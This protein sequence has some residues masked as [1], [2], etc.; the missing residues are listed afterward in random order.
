MGMPI[1]VI[2][3]ISIL[4][5]GLVLLRPMA[6]LVLLIYCIALLRFPTVFPSFVGIFTQLS[7]VKLL[8]GLTFCSVLIHNLVDKKK[9]GLLKA[10]Q[11]KF[12]ILFLLWVAISG[13]SQPC[14]FTRESFTRYASFAMLF[15]ITISMVDSPKRFRLVLWSCIISMLGAAGLA[16]YQHIR[17]EGLIRARS[18]FIDSNYF[19]LYL[20]P[21]IAVAFYRIFDE[22]AFIKKLIAVAATIVLIVAVVFTFSRGGMIGLATVLLLLALNAKRKFLAFLILGVII[23]IFMTYMPY[24]F[25]EKLELKEENP[26]TSTYRRILLLKGGWRMFLDKPLT[27]VGVG[28]FY[29]NTGK[30]AGV[31]AGYAHDMYIEVAAELG[32]VGIFLFMGIIFLTLRDLRKITKMVKSTSLKNY[33]QGLYVGLIGFLVSALFLHAEYEK[34]L[35]LFI[36]LTIC[37]KKLATTKGKVII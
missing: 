4:V 26:V 31:S 18:T 8:G 5:T 23:T 12:F 10:K 27:G 19:N 32:L 17:A 21:V 36:F 30:Y 37:L 33:A 3:I 7:V 15:Y 28:N 14:S 11:T 25:Q 2:I 1:F 29:W 34:F 35:W 13:F 16:L 24:Y 9:I 22:R 6:G 20:L